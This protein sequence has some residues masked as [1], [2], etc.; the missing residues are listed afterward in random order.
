[1]QKTS[2]EQLI[3]FIREQRVI[4]DEKLAQLY[5]VSTKQINQA[6]KRNQDRFPDDFAFQLT[7]EEFANL[8]SQFVTSRFPGNHGGRRHLPWAF[9]EHGVLMAANVLKSDTAIE[10]SLFLVRAFIRLREQAAANLTI[11]KRLAEIDRTLLQ[12]DGALRDLYRKL[13]PLLQ[14][15]P[16]KG[17][18]RK[19]GFSPEKP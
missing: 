19:L 16:E 18:G 7:P 6:V 17:K 8:R 5:G 3:H 14:P 4:L 15:E 12:H 1:M 13:M 10:M 9:S 2:V 11:L